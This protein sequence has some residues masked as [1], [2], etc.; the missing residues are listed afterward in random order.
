M[1]ILS[2][3][4][5]CKIEDNKLIIEPRPNGKTTISVIRNLLQN[6]PFIN[7]I[8]ICEGIEIIGDH[9]FDGLNN[10]VK[11]NLPNSLKLIGTYAFSCCRNLKEI[12]FPNNPINKIEIGQ[13]AFEYCT[14]LEN[15]NIEKGVVKIGDSAFCHCT[16]LQNVYLPDSLM[17]LGEHVFHRCSKLKTIKFPKKIKEIKPYSF[18]D[19]ESLETFNIP[20][21]VIKISDNAFLHCHS[22]TNVEFNE[23]LQEIGNNAFSRSNLKIVKL[24]N[25]LKIMNNNAFS[26][27]RNLESIII[28][29]G[30]EKIGE[31][32]FGGCTNL[33]N[34][35]LPSNIKYLSTGL[36]CDCVDLE[37]IAIPDSVTALGECVFQ[38]CK[39]L[40]DV[41]L[42]KNI[43]IIPKHTFKQCYMIEKIEI[44][45]GVEELSEYSFDHCDSLE[46]IYLPSTLQKINC[47]YPFTNCI[48]LKTIYLNTPN[49][50]EKIDKKHKDFLYNEE[51]LL[52]LRDND[53]NEYSFYH[54]NNYV[55]FNGSFITENKKFE[56]ISSFIGE[57]DYIKLYYWGNKRYVPGF[58]VLMHM[59]LDDID[60]FYLNDNGHIWSKLLK[61]SR[62]TLTGDKTSFFKLCYVLGVFSESTKVR[63]RAVNFLNEKIINKLDGSQIHSKFDGFDLS[64]GF[65]E[66]YAEFFIKYYNDKDFMIDIDEDEWGDEEETDLMAASYNNFK[67]VK[68]I[69]PN[70]TL[71][72]NREADL[73]LPEHVM[74]ACRTIEY[75]DVDSDN[76]LFAL[77]VG[78]YGYTQEQFETL[79]DWYNKGKINKMKLFI[80]K[81]YEEN[82][83][84]YN[85]LRREDPLNA[86]LGNITNCCQ[87]L[88]GLGQSCVEYGMT[89]PNS[90]FI[91]FNY[92]DK[93]IGQ[94]WV[95]Y[96]EKS[97][98]ICLDNIEIPHRYLEKINQNEIIQKSFIDCL[99]RV[100]KSFIEEMNSRG[101]EVK[102]V[103][104][105]QGYNDIKEIL[106]KTFSI[107]T[108]H[109]YLSDYNG[110]SDAAS[111][112]EISNINRNNK[113]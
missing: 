1:R 71:H 45:E 36:F 74:N 68:K 65:N 89:M 37:K 109:C 107:S 56:N 23:G 91:T 30:I 51:N 6:N 25:S 88:G 34:V 100:K 40:K 50:V 80:A 90:G 47:G 24:P 54:K 63:D 3:K 52:L 15:L 102:K 7:E 92:N 69:Y 113:R 41:N 2:N 8:V 79:Q 66:E 98:T 67:N 21:D 77:T 9:Y 105:G 73:L 19:C 110:Y 61:D 97:K 27:C 12:S 58:L 57:K 42:P 84:T 111:Q 75:M 17:L 32:A 44:P 13:K 106:S 16:L 85:L 18:C 93:I 95:W 72:T 78:R 83:I 10:I 82:G 59:P 14:S 43:K 112:Y 94:S 33:K 38:N 104:I 29:D 53:K 35:Y 60:K 46:E 86:V 87:V 101:L 103:T 81:D 5:K 64:N 28:N 49:G 26:G 22:L 99:L 62:I 108:T 4:F 96:D 39:N 70:K 48:S 11:V 55:K 20:S 31:Y 76:E